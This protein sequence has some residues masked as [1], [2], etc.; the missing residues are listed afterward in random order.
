MQNSP[1][2]R[3][4]KSTFWFNHLNT[5]TEKKLSAKLLEIYHL[6]AR[7]IIQ[8][9]SE[10]GTLKYWT[11][12]CPVFGDDETRSGYVQSFKVINRF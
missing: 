11:I 2:L 6:K 4:N 8:W 5:G 3:V 7:Q 9:G 10:L 12:L 1:H